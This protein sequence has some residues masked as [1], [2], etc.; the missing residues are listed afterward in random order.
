[1]R[2][3]NRRAPGDTALTLLSIMRGFLESAMRD[4]LF[5]VAAI[6]F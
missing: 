2:A 3:N 5:L 1:M 6:G 4:I